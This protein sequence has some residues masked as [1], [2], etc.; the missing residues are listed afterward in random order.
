MNKDYLTKFLLCLLPFTWGILFYGLIWLSS[1]AA[2]TKLAPI[3]N[4]ATLYIPAVLLTLFIV[5]KIYGPALKKSLAT[6]VIFFGV[7]LPVIPLPFFIALI[8]IGLPMLPFANVTLVHFIQTIMIGAT[9]EELLSRAFFIKYRNMGK[10]FLLWAPLLSATFSLNHWFYFYAQN[11]HID[12]TW[13]LAFQRFL[14]HFGY[15]FILSMLTYKTKRLEIPTILHIIGNINGYI[16]RYSPVLNSLIW[17]ILNW[18]Q[19][20]LL[21]GM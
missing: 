8:F 14:V 3:V 21:T 18:L 20:L 17:N 1:L 11:F 12:P 13:Q 9:L 10:E 15:G 5:Y 4:E 6:P 7:R 16:Y 2:G 19:Y